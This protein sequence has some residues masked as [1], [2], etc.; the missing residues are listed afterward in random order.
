MKTYSLESHLSKRV[1]FLNACIL[2]FVALLINVLV[3]IWLEHEFDEALEAKVNVLVTLMKDT[4]DGLDFDFADEFMPEFEST[5]QSEYFQIWLDD[6]SVFERSHS[7]GDDKNLPFQKITYPDYLY[8]DILLVDGRQGRMIQV[9][10]LPQIPEDIDRTPE[11][12]ASQKLVTLVLA[13]E[14]EKLDLLLYSIHII[15][16]VATIIILFF[17]NYL[18]KFTVRKSLLPLHIIKK[19]IQKLDADNL[20][21]RLVVAD[22]PYELQDVIKQFNYLLERLGTSFHREQRF[23]SDVAHELRT[24]IAELRSMSEVAL[25]WPD[26]ADLAKQF[27]SGVFESSVQMELLVNNLLAL[28]RCEKGNVL[29]EPQ[30]LELC[31]LINISWNHYEHDAI[32]KHLHFNCSVSADVKIFISANEFEQIINNLISNAVSYSVDSSDVKFYL[33]SENNS[34]DISL[35]ISNIASDLEQSDL[36]LIFDRLWRKS[37][38][39]SSSE[40]SGLGLALVKAYAELLGLKITAELFDDK[41][42]KVSIKNLHIL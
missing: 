22:P 34:S 29:L 4:P 15:T 24:P 28:V 9:V 37:Q 32:E 2:V 13:R 25:K 36:P 30:T 16:A 14:R 1:V 19:Q 11:K 7:L 18:V 6:N 35:I 5:E 3:S 17:I 39:R 31:E 8:K 21:E 27:F 33:E 26:D 38:S 40:H 10:F 41:T 12:L 23:S 42:F 20:K